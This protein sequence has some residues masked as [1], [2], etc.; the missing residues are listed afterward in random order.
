MIASFG[1]E[2]VFL[3]KKKNGKILENFVFTSVKK[4]T[5]VSKIL[6]KKFSNFFI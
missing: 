2:M 3:E 5:N 1:S 6:G 4:L